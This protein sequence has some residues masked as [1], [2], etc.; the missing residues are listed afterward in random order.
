VL[1]SWVFPFE[2]LEVGQSQLVDEDVLGSWCTVGCL[3]WVACS[4]LAYFLLGTV[5]EV[6]LASAMMKLSPVTCQGKTHLSKIVLLTVVPYSD[7]M[8]P[9]QGLELQSHQGVPSEVLQL[10]EKVRSF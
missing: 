7:P 4:H 8:G 9:G 1:L 2:G 3:P 10:V 6:D 5:Q